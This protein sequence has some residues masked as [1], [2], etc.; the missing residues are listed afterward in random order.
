MVEEIVKGVNDVAESKNNG[1]PF[2]LSNGGRGERS[3]MQCVLLYWDS[4]G[5]L[6]YRIPSIYAGFCPEKIQSLKHAPILASIAIKCSPT[7]R[8]LGAII[9]VIMPRL[10]QEREGIIQAIPEFPLAL[11]AQILIA[12]P[13]TNQKILFGVLETIKLFLRGAQVYPSR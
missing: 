1:G 13:T 8:L 3:P 5:F 4:C 12:S 9:R 2:F 11:L 7:T 10:D 6:I